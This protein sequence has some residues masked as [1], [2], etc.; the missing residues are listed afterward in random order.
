MGKLVLPVI[1]SI[2]VAI[3]WTKLF[4][5]LVNTTDNLLILI[6]YTI[7]YL[8]GIVAIVFGIFRLTSPP[9]PPRR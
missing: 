9:S 4:I 8:G 6:A 1:I 5:I 3:P 7:I 2:L